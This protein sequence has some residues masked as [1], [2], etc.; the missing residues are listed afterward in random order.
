MSVKIKEINHEKYEVLEHG[1]TPGF[2][3]V[4]HI[5]LSIAVLYFIFIFAH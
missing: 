5:I 4:F 3:T 2:K 1:Q